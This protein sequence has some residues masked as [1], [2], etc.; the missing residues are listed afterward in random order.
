MFCKLTGYGYRRRGS[1][2]EDV[3]FY[4]LFKKQPIKEITT[5]Q[6]VREGDEDSS[7]RHIK[8]E[9]VMEESGKNS[10]RTAGNG[11]QFSSKVRSR[12]N[13]SQH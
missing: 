7:F 12:N 6:V 2:R 11:K 9:E 10:R 13:N 4:G 8:F 3:M 5:G 1:V